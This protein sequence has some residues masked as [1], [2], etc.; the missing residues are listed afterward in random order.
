MFMSSHGFWLE[1]LLVLLFLVAPVVPTCLHLDKN[2][3]EEIA[4]QGFTLCVFP[5]QNQ[6]LH[7]LRH[8]SLDFLSRP[9]FFGSQ[10]PVLVRPGPLEA[11]P[12]LVPHPSAGCYG[13]TGGR[14]LAWFSWNELER[15]ARARSC[16]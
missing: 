13:A 5:F 3:R 7:Q 8:K 12:S 6:A 10:E 9:D 14:N 4:V 15:P 11:E 1:R 16:R 2:S